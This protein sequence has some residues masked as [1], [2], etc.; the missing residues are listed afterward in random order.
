MDLTFYNGKTVFITGHTGFK[1]TWLCRILI[2]AGAK[3]IG[4][5][6]EPPTNPS[7]YALTETNNDVHSIIGD[8]RDGLKLVDSIKATKPEI[9]L[10]HSR[11]GVFLIKNQ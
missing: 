3:V 10:Q 4:Y 1:G 6:L 2:N 11:W 5:A 8:I 9:I 7:L